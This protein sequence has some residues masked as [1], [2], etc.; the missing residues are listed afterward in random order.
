MI[1]LL[2][3]I[4]LIA[5]LA[6]LLLPALAKAKQKALAVN[7]VSN[8]KQWSL[9]WYLYADDHQGS[10]SPGTTVSWQRGEWVV[11]LQSYYGKKLQLLLCPAATMRRGPGKYEVRV[12]A[13]S[14]AT[15]E[16]GGP[17]TA[18]EFPLADPSVAGRNLIAS[19]GENNWVY[20]PAPSVGNIQGRLTI[21]NWRKIYAP[22]HPT[23]TPLFGDCM[24]RGGGPDTAGEDG[25]RPNFNGEWSGAGYEFKHFAMVRHG[26][27]IILTTFDGSVRQRRTRELWRL[28]WHRQFDVTYADAHN[29]GFFPSW[30]P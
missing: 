22:T 23:D 24:W 2:V 21:K 1:E 3:V 12:P 8:L 7:C 26:K 9:F 20:N 29:P 10:F 15:V 18:V 11:S 28:Y 19:Y 13:G 14:T 27:G 6:A 25:I 17:T 30:M 16:W 4:A 5:I